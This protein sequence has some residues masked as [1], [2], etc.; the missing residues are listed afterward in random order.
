M[1]AVDLS[2]EAYTAMRLSSWHEVGSKTVRRCIAPQPVLTRY[3]L[4]EIERLECGIF[5]PPLPPPASTGGRG[6]ARLSAVWTCGSRW[7]RIACQGFPGARASGR[8]VGER[9]RDV[10]SPRT[11]ERAYCRHRPPRCGWRCPPLCQL[12]H[13][14]GRGPC[15]RGRW[16]SRVLEGL[17]LRAPARAEQTCQL[18]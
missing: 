13:E 3:K 2:E 14:T 11:S 4:L 12:A 5:A 10:P 6:V 17:C 15:G 18:A 7:V 1:V 8:P 9:W 16:L